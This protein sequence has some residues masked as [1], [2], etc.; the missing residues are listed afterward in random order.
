MTLVGEVVPV[1]IIHF[2]ALGAW[3]KWQAEVALLVGEDSDHLLDLVGAVYGVAHALDNLH[4][5]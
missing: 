1:A 2:E 3:P 5:T 4:G